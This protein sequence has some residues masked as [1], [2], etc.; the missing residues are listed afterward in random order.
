MNSSA[1]AVALAFLLFMLSLWVCLIKIFPQT[2]P[3]KVKLAV[4]FLVDVV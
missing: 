3:W 2:V 4:V 1:L